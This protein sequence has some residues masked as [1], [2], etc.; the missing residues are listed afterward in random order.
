MAM[1]WLNHNAG[2]T[3]TLYA[4][5][6]ENLAY[7]SDGTFLGD[8]FGPYSYRVIEPLLYN[9]SALF[10]ELNKMGVMYFL[11]SSNNDLP[12]AFNNHKLFRLV[13]KGSHVYLYELALGTYNW[14]GTNDNPRCY[15][16]CVK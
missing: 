1:D 4:Y 6:V 11:Y 13:W 14:R 5:R 15:S 3:Y 12:T 16:H 8:H 7:F 2:N 9:A 10:T